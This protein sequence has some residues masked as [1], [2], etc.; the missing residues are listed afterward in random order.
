MFFRSFSFFRLKRIKQLDGLI[1]RE[2]KQNNELDHQ[3]AALK[4][5]IDDMQFSKDY[6]IHEKDIIARNER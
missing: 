3:I 1:D 4:V 2:R 5:N 6:L